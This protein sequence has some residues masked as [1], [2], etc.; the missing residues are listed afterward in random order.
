M[1]KNPAEYE[2]DIW[3]AKFTAISSQVSPSSLS[4]VSAGYYQE[5]MVD[6]SGMIRTQMGKHN[7]SVMV[8]VLGTPCTTPTR[9]SNRKSKVKSKAVPLHAI[10]ALGGRGSIAPTHSRPGH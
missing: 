5:G 4:D 7:R 3:S 10:E 9:D 2:G 1:L 6:E 8:P